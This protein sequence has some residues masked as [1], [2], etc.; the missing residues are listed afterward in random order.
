MRALVAAEGRSI[1][2]VT[3]NLTEAI[4]FSDRVLLMTTRTG[5]IV[6]QIIARDNDEQSRHTRELKRDQLWQH[7][8]KEVTKFGGPGIRP[9]RS[10]TPK[11]SGPGPRRMDRSVSAPR[12]TM[13]ED[14]GSTF[15]RSIVPHTVA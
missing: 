4:E 11:R 14:P 5:Q 6:E 12:L 7:L 1:L 10:S 8:R 15:Q 9:T 13:T 2:F 3:H